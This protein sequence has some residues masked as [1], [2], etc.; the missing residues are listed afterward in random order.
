VIQLT[1]AAAR[2]N[3][4]TQ[5]SIIIN[6]RIVSDKTFATRFVSFLKD[7]Q[8]NDPMSEDELEY[9]K[10]VAYELL[11]HQDKTCTQNEERNYLERC[12]PMGI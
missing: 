12:H 10:E 7:I 3:I 5:M 6:K 9:L 1:E 4:L 8:V 11:K 2:L